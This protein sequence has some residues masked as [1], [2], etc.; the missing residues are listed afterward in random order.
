M[1][2]LRAP[3]PSPRD[4]QQEGSAMTRIRSRL[5]PAMAVALLALFLALGTP[6]VWGH[7]GDGQKI[8]ACV[9]DSTG[10]VSVI[11]DNTGFGNPDSRCQRPSEQHALDWNVAGPAGPPGATGPAGPAGVPG[12]SESDSIWWRSGGEK[13]LKKPLQPDGA[14]KLIARLPVPSGATYMANASLRLGAPNLWVAC[15]LH[16]AVGD[17]AKGVFKMGVDDA[18]VKTPFASPVL[19]QSGF[20]QSHEI[21]VDLHGFLRLSKPR[22]DLPTWLSVSCASHR[23]SQFPSTDMT[24][25]SKVRLSVVKLAGEG[26]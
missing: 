6:V 14:H 11:A 2:A 9:T 10:A 18:W 25:I 8:H 15:Y 22:T 23:N 5:S 20:R 21:N 13:T 26:R 3:R 17:A 1:K 4:A 24:Q 16:G 7:G 19:G 12:S